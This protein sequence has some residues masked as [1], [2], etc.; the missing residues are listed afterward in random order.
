MI[1]LM[2]SLVSKRA[3]KINLLRRRGRE[4]R[5]PLSAGAIT[6]SVVFYFTNEKF[7]YQAMQQ[8]QLD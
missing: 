7:K 5:I 4:L 3:V 6:A 8:L 1:L 2:V